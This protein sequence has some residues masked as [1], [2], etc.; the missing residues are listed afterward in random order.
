MTKRIVVAGGGFGGVNV[1]KALERLLPPGTAHV[2]LVNE[3]N[4]MLYTPFMGA[5]A[6]GSLDPRHIAFPLREELDR[7]EIRVARIV[8]ADPERHVLRLRDL[9]GQETELGYDR[10]VVSLGSVSRTPPVPGVEEHALGFKTLTEAVA[11]RD[12]LLRTFETAEALGDVA[13]LDAYLTFVIVGAGYAGLAA[14][15]EAQAFAADILPLYPRCRAHGMRWILV[16]SRERMMTDMPERLARFAERELQSRGVELLTEARV[17]ELTADR[18][19]LSTGATVPTRT[20]VWAAG[21]KPNPVVVRL[22]LPLDATGRIEVDA[23][24][25]VRGQHNVWAIGDA[26]AV[27]DP[28][29]PGE[30]CPPTRQHTVRQARPVAANVA[31]SLGAGTMEPFT[32]RTRGVFVDL[33]RFEAVAVFFRLRLSGRGAWMLTRGY[34]LKQVPTPQRKLRL[35]SDWVIDLFRRDTTDLGQVGRR[36]SEPGAPA[37]DP[38][39]RDT[40]G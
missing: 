19:R 20:V 14:T 15:A 36:I 9:E 33:G 12:R 2:T 38:I 35:I 24:M 31:A 8:G 29:R 40:S 18:A 25:R 32:Y 39:D 16:D 30:A 10:L 13:D 27:P 1:A 34:H 37:L 6:G 5:V 3:R 4:Y 23:Y 17:V 26:A 11:L 28:A 7:T 22:G 21:V